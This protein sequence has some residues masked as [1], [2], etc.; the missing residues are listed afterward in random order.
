VKK[1]ELNFAKFFFGSK[2]ALLDHVHLFFFSSFGEVQLKSGP[3]F[4]FEKVTR[5]G[6]GARGGLRSEPG[7]F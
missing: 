3:M 1:I 5:G 4:V 7:I 2:L 6:G